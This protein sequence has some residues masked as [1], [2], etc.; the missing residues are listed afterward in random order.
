M[1]KNKYDEALISALIGRETVITKKN[2]DRIKFNIKNEIKYEELD[3]EYLKKIIKLKQEE[4]NHTNIFAFIA[5]VVSLL[6]ML[7]TV[8]DKILIQIPGWLSIVFITG[9]AI[10]YMIS[11][12]NKNK[13]HNRIRKECEILLIAIEEL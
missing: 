13:K 11:L 6:T 3:I 4:Y 9:V 7:I 5:F 10:F 1:D 2:I 8:L 12:Q